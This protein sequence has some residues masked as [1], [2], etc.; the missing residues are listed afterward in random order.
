MDVEFGKKLTFKEVESIYGRR[1]HIDDLLV[2]ELADEDDDWMKAF[3]PN[4]G[5]R[6][7]N[8]EEEIDDGEGNETDRP[9]PT[10]SVGSA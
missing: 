2:D 9:V 7:P 3:C 6:V 8:L 1:K 5:R 10:K 4:C